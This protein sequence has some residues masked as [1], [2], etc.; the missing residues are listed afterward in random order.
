MQH[1]VHGDTVS[2]IYRRDEC[3]KQSLQEAAI[4]WQMTGFVTVYAKAVISCIILVS[5]TIPLTATAV[6]ETSLGKVELDRVSRETEFIINSILHFFEN[7]RGTG[8]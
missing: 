3:T 1:V 8:N 4:F 5:N 7:N 2:Y 6:T